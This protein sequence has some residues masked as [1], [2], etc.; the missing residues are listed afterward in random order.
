M[1]TPTTIQWGTDDVILA[2]MRT[3]DYPLRAL[4]DMAVAHFHMYHKKIAK[5]AGRNPND[6]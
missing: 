2:V 6:D 4:I 1:H 5:K 3:T